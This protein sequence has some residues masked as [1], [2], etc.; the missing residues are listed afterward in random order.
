MNHETQVNNENQVNRK[1]SKLSETQLPGASFE[2][3][4][5]S[6]PTEPQVPCGIKLNQVKQVS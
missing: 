2:P 1:Q 5:P 3:C 6:E 4:Q